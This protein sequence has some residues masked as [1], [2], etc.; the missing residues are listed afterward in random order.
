[1]KAKRLVKL[2]YTRPATHPPQIL[3]G[4]RYHLA[5]KPMGNRTMNERHIT[6][7]RPWKSTRAVD[8]ILKGWARLLAPSWFFTPQKEATANIHK[9]GGE[10][11]PKHMV[12]S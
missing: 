7:Y 2:R 12:T 8:A 1:M 10:R 6:L 9:L 4:N 5:V 3:T 11:G